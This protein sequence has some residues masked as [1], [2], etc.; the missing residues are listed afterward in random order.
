M[1]DISRIK[2]KIF[3]DS[4]G[5]SEFGQ[6]GSNQAAPPGT[7]TKDLDLIQA[8][9]NYDQGWFAATANAG[10]PPRIQDMNSLF[11]LLTTQLK[12]MYQ[13]GIPE[14]LDDA[15]ERYYVNKSFVSKNG[16]VFIAVL[17]DDVTN[18]NA[19]K[20]PETETS[21][22]LEILSSS[23]SWPIGSTYIQFPGDSDPSTLDLPGT[24]SNVSSELAG[25]FIRFE[26]G[27]ATAFE[28]G[29]QSDAMQSVTGQFI[30]SQH[31]ASQA[32]ASGVHTSAATGATAPN[33]AGS[34]SGTRISF[35]NGDSTSPNPA[36]TD[37]VETRAV[38]R[39]VRKWR[40]TA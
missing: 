16:K 39:T 6:F 37:S 13:K 24:W 23:G 21:W 18:I 33:A 40:R 36:K 14:W 29:Q 28:A 5:V 31:W 1:A 38:N 25:D 32:S 12:Y 26:G 19:Q 4:G 30:L 34:L 2:Q 15:D 11:L 17:G 9:S 20:D 10:E 3:G 27:E 35:D 7:T 8:L 22:W